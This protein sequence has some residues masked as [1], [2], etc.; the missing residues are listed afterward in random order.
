MTGDAEVVKKLIR[1]PKN[2]VFGPARGGILPYLDI[3]S[4]PRRPRTL[5]IVRLSP[6][7]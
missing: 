3:F 2:P 7:T 1:S 5:G 6:L 4:Q